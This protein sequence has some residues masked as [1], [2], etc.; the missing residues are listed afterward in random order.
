MKEAYLYEKLKD[1][2]VRCL[3]CNHYCEIPENKTGICRV[4]KIIMGKLYSLVY[5]KPCAVSIEPIE[6]KPLYHFLPGTQTLSLATVG[7]NFSC[8]SCQN[9]TISQGPKIFKRIE[10]EKV[11][12]KEIVKLAKEKELPSIS[13]TFTE[14]TIFLEYA[15]DIMKL[16]KKQGIKNIWVT[17]GFF[18]KE[19]LNLISPYLDAVNVDLKSFSDDFYRKFCGGTLQPVLSNLK[20]LVKNKV[21]VEITTLIIPGLN[22]SEKELENIAKFIKNELGQNVPWHISRF[23]GDISWK[24]QDIPDTPIET[25]LKA[26]KIGKKAGL[27]YIYL[28]NV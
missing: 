26:E 3:G 9:W 4:K 28:G 27:K 23:F 1:N 2:K 6:K 16:A 12:C 13:Y 21:W 14:P 19:T 5:E 15:F 24:F 22:D 17:N 25:L 8:Y 10:G 11:S 20:E 7:C 18:S